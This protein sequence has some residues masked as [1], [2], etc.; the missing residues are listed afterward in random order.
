MIIKYELTDLYSD[1]EV[2]EHITKKHKRFVETAHI[3]LLHNI[4]RDHYED[5][6][7]KLMERFSDIW[8]SEGYHSRRVALILLFWLRSPRDGMG[9]R[10]GFQNILRWLATEAPDGQQWIQ[11]GIKLVPSYGR[12]DDLTAFFETVLEKEA[13]EYWANAINEQNYEACK[14][15][16]RKMRPLQKALGCNEAALRKKLCAGRAGSLETYMCQ[17]RW[18]D[19]PYEK[20]SSYQIR[21]NRNA[22]I[23]HDSERFQT[24]CREKHAQ[25][26]QPRN[27][28]SNKSQQGWTNELNSWITANSKTR[29]RFKLL[30]ALLGQNEI[31]ALVPPVNY[32]QEEPVSHDD[33]G[34]HNTDLLVASNKWDW[35]ARLAVGAKYKIKSWSDIADAINT[36]NTKE[37]VATILGYKDY[38][39]FARFLKRQKIKYPYDQSSH[40]HDLNLFLDQALYNLMHLPHHPQ[41]RITALK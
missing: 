27:A 11:D 22:F 26:S 36:A 10:L 28:T 40:L 18:G 39:N 13:A 5:Y 38:E 21:L 14:W 12:W 7:R 1:I 23:R 24:F 31:A 32:Q 17:N 3:L 9:F 37:D 4:T 19:I 2:A 33:T 30:N 25:R 34:V 6:A 15:A 41:R 8:I 20:L 35:Q 16:D 29:N